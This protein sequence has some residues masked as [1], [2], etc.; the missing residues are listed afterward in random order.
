MFILTH[1]KSCSLSKYAHY[2]LFIIINTECSKCTLCF[3]ECNHCRTKRVASSLQRI[4]VFFCLDN[5]FFF[6]PQAH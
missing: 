2:A 6:F 4:K 1:V 5:A 3:W